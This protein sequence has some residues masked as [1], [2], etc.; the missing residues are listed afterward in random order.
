MA[1][2]GT[3][4]LFYICMGYIQTNAHVSMEK[5]QLFIRYAN[6]VCYNHFHS[7]ALKRFGA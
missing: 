4:V 6:C 2:S 3:A 7:N 5:Q 1:C